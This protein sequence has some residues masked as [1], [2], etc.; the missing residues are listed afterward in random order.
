MATDPTA[1]TELDRLMAA[2]AAHDD[3]RRATTEWKQVF[4]LLQK[5][6]LP[7]GRVSH[8]VAMRDPAQLAELIEQLRAAATDDAAPASAADP[9]TCRRALRAF[10][11][12][13]SLTVL[14]EESRLGHGAL[15]KG[16]DASVPAVIPP[17][18]WP[19]PVWQELVRQ[20][21]LRYLGHGFYGLAE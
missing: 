20:G 5:T 16:S 17:N 6:D 11:K 3:P 9:E 19:E 7:A 10:R 21:K 14:D 12:R 15:T 18:Q 4:R 1:A 2:I 8:V 13:L